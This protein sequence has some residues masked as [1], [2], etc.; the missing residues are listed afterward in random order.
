MKHCTKKGY[1]GD[2]AHAVWRIGYVVGRAGAARSGNVF[3]EDETMRAKG[4]ARQAAA[5]TAAT[6]S[7]AST[8]KQLTLNLKP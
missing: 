8:N 1:G 2:C 6:L 7:L 4:A 5:A 3:G